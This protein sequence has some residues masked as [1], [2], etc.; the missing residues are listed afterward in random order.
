MRRYVLED[1]QSEN[2]FIN[3]MGFFVRYCTGSALLVTIHII[4]TQ[5]WAGGHRC[6]LRHNVCRPA[7]DAYTNTNT[8]INKKRTGNTDSF[9]YIYLRGIFDE[10]RLDEKF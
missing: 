5:S 3:V 6:S 7:T 2:M 1:V 9:I 8:N 10:K 4:C